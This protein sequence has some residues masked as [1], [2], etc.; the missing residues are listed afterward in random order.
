MVAVTDA[1]LEHARAGDDRAFGELVAPYR[2]ELHVHCYRMLGTVSDAEDLVQETLLAAWRGLTGF[3]GRT[4]MRSWLYRIATNRCL[5]MLRDTGRR[6][7]PPAVAP[8]DPP[9]PTRHGEVT[10]LQPYPD[11]LL[12]QVPDAA[13]GP[14]ARFDQREAS[15]LAFVTALQLLPP[16]QAAALILCDVLGYRLAETAELLDT[17]PAAVKGMLQRAR[18]SIDRGEV[19][20]AA[21]RPTDRS[22]V[23][24]FATAFANRDIDALLSLLTDDAWLAM[25]PAPHE[26]HGRPA[27]AAFLQVSGAWRGARRLV[28]VPIGANNQPAFGCYLAEPDTTVATP[29]GIM[30]LTPHADRIRAMTR[31]FLPA[32]LLPHFGLPE[33]WVLD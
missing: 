20:K 21:A 8:F 3:E 24:R 27:I 23:H 2:A 30:V 11:T 7:P 6:V 28:L 4:S 15:E 31:F 33:T 13:P 9:A 18:S 19:E 14:E 32:G 10:W 16:R 25:P 22:A 26:Y 12:D 5:N 29:A 17:T 1:L